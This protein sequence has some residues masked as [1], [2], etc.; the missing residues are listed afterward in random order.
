MSRALPA[1]F[2]SM[3]S[4]CQSSSE[5]SSTAAILPTQNHTGQM[6]YAFIRFNYKLRTSAWGATECSTA[7]T[8]MTGQ[9]RYKQLPVRK[10]YTSSLHMR[11]RT[12]QLSKQCRAHGNQ[13]DQRVP[14]EG[15]CR[16]LHAAIHQSGQ[17]S[18]ELI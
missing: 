17:Q 15:A 18:D 8:V 4:R 7:R 9:A 12:V 2:G 6:I 11:V 5:S 10:S 14:A 1:T 3:F 16:H 13:A